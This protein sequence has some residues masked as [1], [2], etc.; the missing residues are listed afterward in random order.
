MSNTL[1]DF[2][3]PFAP[4]APFASL[5]ALPPPAQRW[6]DVLTGAPQ[7]LSEA[8]T[9]AIGLQGNL[10]QR[11]LAGQADPFKALAWWH[12]PAPAAPLDWA[13]T[14]SRASAVMSKALTHA[15]QQQMELCQSWLTAQQQFTST[16][17][18]K[19]LHDRVEW[20]H[21]QT[22]QAVTQLREI[23]D[24]YLEA[25]FAAA[26]IIADAWPAATPGETVVHDKPSNHAAAK[27]ADGGQATPAASRAT[28]KRR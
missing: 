13:D 22:T 1:F 5:N 17:D 28:A 8:M 26:G 14:C 18:A 21:G 16:T 10:Y 3:L 12:A 9:G 11:L 20:L 6:L 23:N 2:T 25:W 19:G 24:E 27:P 7:S 4:F 15:A